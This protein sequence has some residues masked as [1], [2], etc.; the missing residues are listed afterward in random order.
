ML[1]LLA[2]CLAA[3]NRPKPPEPVAGTPGIVL[4]TSR[5]ALVIRA[6]DTRVITYKLVE[7]T[8]FFRGNKFINYSRLHENS[9]VVVES[10]SDLDGKLTAIVVT[11]QDKRPSLQSRATA[12][13]LLPGGVPTDPLIAEARTAA[14]RLDQMLPNFLCQQFTSRLWAGADRKWRTIDQI[15]A[16]VLINRGRETYR[17][18]KL[19]G[20]P[21]G[22]SIMQLPGSNST[23]EFGTTLRALLDPHTAALFKYQSDQV[24]EDRSTAIYRYAVSGD[25]SNW[26]IAAGSQSLLTPYTGRIWIDRKSGNVVRIE[27][28]AAGIPD[29]FPYRIVDATIEYGPV[30]LADG[31]FFLPVAATNQVCQD[32]PK[33]CSRNQID[34]R[35]YHRYIGESS[36]SFDS[37]PDNPQAKP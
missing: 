17:D 34:F 12:L 4:K 27:K 9:P 33:E 7:T 23:G 36:I 25:L 35:N 28:Q 14:E 20:R 3:A 22:N 19:N 30:T 18:I 15:T 11:L 26:T 5:D 21:M 32:V 6:I 8:T 31:T 24:A 13:S 37:P 16:E 10:T 1:L 2:V 29:S